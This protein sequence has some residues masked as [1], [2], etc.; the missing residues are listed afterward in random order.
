MNLLG[1]IAVVLI[2]VASLVFM[3]LAMAVYA[4]HKNW[5]AAVTEPGGLDEQL[6]LAE[7]ENRQLQERYNRLE[8]NLQAEVAQRTQQLAKAETERAALE[9]ENRQIGEQLATLNQN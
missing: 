5:Y 1:K 3:T 2:L 9:Q 7:E 6:R 8:T 4:T